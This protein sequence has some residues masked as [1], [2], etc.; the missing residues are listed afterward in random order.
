M[1]PEETKPAAAAETKPV[2]EKQTNCL[3]CNK[4][5]KKLKKYYRDGKFYCSKKCWMKF[6]ESKK[7]KVEEK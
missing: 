3:A 4:P 5:I 2:V 1:A 6:K 7:E